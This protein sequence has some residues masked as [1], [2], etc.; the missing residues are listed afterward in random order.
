MP[1]PPSGNGNDR[2]RDRQAA[3]PPTPAKRRR[4]VSWIV[5]LA[6]AV[7]AIVILCVVLLRRGPEVAKETGTAPKTAA[8]ATV[9]RENLAKEVEIPAEFRPYVEVELHA[10]VSG[11]LQT[12]Y[13]DFGDKVKSNQ[14]LAILEVP[15][16]KAQWDAAIAAE[17]RTEA[18]YT[19]AHLI[20]N[21][22]LGV[23]QEHPNLVAQQDIDTAQAKDSVAV[24]AV[25][26]AKAVVERYQTL[27][28]YTKITAPFDGVITWRYVDPGALIEAGT[29]SGQAK[30]VLRISD[31]YHLRMDFWVSVDQVRYVK[32][33]SRVEVRVDSLGG[34][35]YSGVITRFSHEVNDDTRT[36]TT[37]I[38]IPNPNLE[39]T[40][41]MYAAVVF[42]VQQRPNALAVPIE[43]VS[44]GD[45]PT[46]YLVNSKNEIE[47]RPVT[48]GLETATRYEI[49]DG[50]KEGD[51]VVIGIRS[52]FHP[53]EKID[54]KPVQA[55]SVDRS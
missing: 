11:Y 31:N 9:D 32:D 49:L 13:V 5:A 42:K 18:D 52:E 19:N 26:A 25:A 29:S 35:K 51:R 40:P 48:L 47:E 6:L 30:P 53:G 55:T 12:M 21:R 3:I 15:E 50:L 2:A 36:M 10:K 39:L 24:A 28:S 43:A 14:V 44:S 33:G 46:V 16:L 23:N 7:A 41:G 8:V 34:K 45:K 22:L 38:E 37:E 20:Y 1:P 4:K 17:E 54:P 27:F